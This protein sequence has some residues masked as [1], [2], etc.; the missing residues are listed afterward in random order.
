MTPRRNQCS[1]ATVTY[2]AAS[3]QWCSPLIR[4]AANLVGRE[5]QDVTNR[6]ERLARSSN[7]EVLL[8]GVDVGAFHQR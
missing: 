1:F 6:D 2:H 7:L 8:D 3:A 5:T 4:I